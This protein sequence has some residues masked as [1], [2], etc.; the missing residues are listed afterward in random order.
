MRCIEK[1]LHS[2]HN[3]K[4]PPKH[5]KKPSLHRSALAQPGIQLV[6]YNP[7]QLKLNVA[8]RDGGWRGMFGFA[9]YFTGGSAGDRGLN[10]TDPSPQAAP[11]KILIWIPEEKAWASGSAID[12][13]RCGHRVAA[14]IASWPGGEQWAMDGFALGFAGAVSNLR[15]LAKHMTTAG[16]L[17]SPPMHAAHLAAALV[18]VYL[19]R[20]CSL[21][22]AAKAAFAK[23]QGNFAAACVFPN[24]QVLVATSRACPL[25]VGGDRERSLAASSTTMFRAIGMDCRCLEKDDLA[26]LRPGEIVLV[27]AD[28]MRISR[29]L[30]RNQ[31]SQTTRNLTTA[32]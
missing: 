3:R 22:A 25:A 9:A 10:L 30:D 14:L 7:G 15:V 24:E 32:V 26:V 5:W 19:K 16:I 2:R 6:R 18:A 27:D 29:Q 31:N 23:L 1:L 17:R 11:T 21:D 4:W 28:G 13:D 12:A 20:G 8:A